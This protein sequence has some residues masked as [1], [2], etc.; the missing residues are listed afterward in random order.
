VGYSVDC[1]SFSLPKYETKTGSAATFVYKR[2]CFDFL[3]SVKMSCFI[4]QSPRPFDEPHLVTETTTM[5]GKS[6][7]DHITDIL[8]IA[9]IEVSSEICHICFELVDEIDAFEDSLSKAKHSL[10]TVFQSGSSNEQR[11][12]LPATTDI[13]DDDPAE[14]DTFTR[15]VE[16]PKFSPSDHPK[17]LIDRLLVKVKW[18]TQHHHKMSSLELEIQADFESDLKEVI[19]QTPVRLDDK[20]ASDKWTKSLLKSECD[21][22][23]FD[24]PGE[25]KCFECQESFDSVMERIFHSQEVHQQCPDLLQCSHCSQIFT[26]EQS[27]WTHI[28]Q[29]H[30]EHIKMQ[31]RDPQLLPNGMLK[32]LNCGLLCKYDLVYRAHIYERHPKY[33]HVTE[34]PVCS[35]SVPDLSTYRR[36]FLIQHCGYTFQC[37]TCPVIFDDLD[38]VTKMLIHLNRHKTK[39]PVVKQRRKGK[40]GRS[41]PAKNPSLISE[42]SNIANNDIFDDDDEYEVVTK[43]K[44]PYVSKIHS[45][46]LRR[47]PLSGVEH[48]KANYDMALYPPYDPS[49][50]ITSFNDVSED[51]RE[52]SIVTLEMLR[53]MPTSISSLESQHQWDVV[54]LKSEVANF[55]FGIP[56]ESK[57]FECI[58]EDHNTFNLIPDRFNHQFTTHNQSSFMCME[59]NKSFHTNDVFMKHLQKHREPDSKID[60][61]PYLITSALPELSMEGWLMC[62]RCPGAFA[63]ELAY[64]MHMFES[65]KRP[66]WALECPVCGK[67]STGAMD[68]KRHVLIIHGGYTHACLICS[69]R[70]RYFYYILQRGV[71]NKSYFQYFSTRDSISSHLRA[72]INEGKNQIDAQGKMIHKRKTKS[73]KY[74]PKACV[75]CSWISKSQLLHDRHLLATHGIQVAQTCSVCQ[76]ILPDPK[77]LVEHRRAVHSNDICYICAKS[78][79]TL[80][81]LNM[82]I[83]RMHPEMGNLGK[84][85]APENAKHKPI[86]IANKK[87]KTMCEICSKMV[88]T[89]N[90]KLHM[91]NHEEKQLL[92]PKCP[93]MFRW[94]SSLTSHLSS[95]H[96]DTV[97]MVTIA[98]EFCGK[99]FKDKSNLRQHRY[100]HTGGPHPCKSCGRGFGRRDLL[101]S[102]EA[103]CTVTSVF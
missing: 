41:S 49:K 3:F 44:R 63:N 90:I 26:D 81:D 19:L 21:Q 66:K 37:N 73:D 47:E 86:K 64:W 72:H 48:F 4:C 74:E 24:I 92:C 57:C 27:A 67:K 103:K 42:D 60:S 100:S 50:V 54:M 34:C 31:S 53:T 9:S 16:L 58:D 8:V 93:R 96:G 30:P 32:C 62:N 85:N 18:K 79:L 5:S 71:R 70:Y 29:N 23:E 89:H 51:L 68:F 95:A 43:L 7:L 2:K 20:A 65:H 45:R 25:V 99:Q 39:K 78:Y 6:I 40:L 61:K 38:C 15:G 36:H 69:K 77:A 97:R 11:R 52:D 76:E 10:K 88:L 1:G 83:S 59:C 82:H 84:G 28:E 98:C 55:N 33:S 12:R 14:L 102:H 46:S 94:N 101:N 56:G 13:V 22:M 91:K 80:S 87:E 75:E 35:R 17:I